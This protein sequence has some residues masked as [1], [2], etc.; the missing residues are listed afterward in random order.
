MILLF[1]CKYRYVHHVWHE[2]V[3]ERWLKLLQSVTVLPV[4]VHEIA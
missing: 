3:Q 4:L 2:N 1:M